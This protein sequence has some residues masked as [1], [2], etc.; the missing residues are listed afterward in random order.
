VRC[1]KRTLRNFSAK[2]LLIIPDDFSLPEDHLKSRV[3]R[4]M[5]ETA[6]RMAGCIKEKKK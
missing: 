6:G 5:P 4:D 1:C 2:H 3:K